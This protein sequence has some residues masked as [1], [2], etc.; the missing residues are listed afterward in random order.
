MSEASHEHQPK[1]PLTLVER[2]AAAIPS[3]LVLSA[4]GA[5]IVATITDHAETKMG[6]L[7]GAPA[8]LYSIAVVHMAMLLADRFK[9]LWVGNYYLS[10]CLRAILFWFWAIVF[11]MVLA[12]AGGGR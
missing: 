2:I 3:L 7:G 5:P 10:M 6:R 8:V 9:V 11:V 4:I 12:K 1:P